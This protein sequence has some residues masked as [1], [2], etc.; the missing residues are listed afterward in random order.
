M[1][2]RELIEELEKYDLDI[3]V[4]YSFGP[5][6]HSDRGYYENLA[7]EPSEGQTI[8]QML[9]AAKGAL[10]G[11][12]YGYKG[13]EFG[14]HEYTEVLIGEDSSVCGDGISPMLIRYMAESGKKPTPSVV[15]GPREEK[16]NG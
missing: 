16:A 15:Q 1:N 6:W 7:F 11:T 12:L 3:V 14:V 4:P 10:G 13:G 9:N 8:G 2:L 5:E